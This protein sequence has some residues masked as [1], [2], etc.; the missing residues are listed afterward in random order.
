[1][2]FLQKIQNFDAAEM[3]AYLVGLKVEVANKALAPFGME[4]PEYEINRA[5]E[6]IEK[7]LKEEV[8]E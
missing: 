3:A 2:T 4:L 6:L 5:Q 8:K 7:Q 1:M